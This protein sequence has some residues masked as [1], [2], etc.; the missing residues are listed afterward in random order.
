MQACLTIRDLSLAE[1]CFLLS[2]SGMDA[3]VK[4]LDFRGMSLFQERCLG[5]FRRGY[6]VLVAV[7]QR[8]EAGEDNV[9][10]HQSCGGRYG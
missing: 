1:L 8:Q 9:M 4:S 5:G 3:A 7:F 2:S 6:G 10:G